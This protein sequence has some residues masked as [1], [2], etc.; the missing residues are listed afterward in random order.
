VQLHNYLT[1]DFEEKKN[2]IFLLSAFNNSNKASPVPVVKHILA[3][4]FAIS[5]VGDPSHF[6]TDWDPDA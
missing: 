5:T 1:Q 3:L 4:T 6:G 2:H